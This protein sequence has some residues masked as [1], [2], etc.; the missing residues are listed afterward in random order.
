MLFSRRTL[1]WLAFAGLIIISYWLR[2]YRLDAV[3]LRGD[4]GFTLIHW[5]AP[6][7]SERWQELLR[8]ERHPVGVYMLY[9]AWTGLAGKSV[10]AVRFL[11]VLGGLLGGAATITLARRLL[12]NRQLL[13]AAAFLWMLN[14]FLLWH[15][16]D[17][18]PYS[19]LVATTTLS[20]YW[21]I[22]TLEQS[23]AAQRL[24]LWLP[25]ILIQSIAIYL[26][27][28]EPFW[29]I[30]QGLYVL[31]FYRT[32]LKQAFKAWLAIALLCLPV[33]LQT[34]WLVGGD[35][36]QGDAGDANWQTFF[37]TFVPT[38]F[39]GDNTIGLFWGILFVMVLSVGMLMLIRYQRANLLLW[40]SLVIPSMLLFIVAH[41]STLSRPRYVIAFIPILLIGI[42][43]VLYSVIRR[44]R[45]SIAMP[46][47]FACVALMGIVSIKEINDYFYHDPAKSP[48]W[49]GL[50]S[51]LSARTTPADIVFSG[52][53]DPTIEYYYHKPLLYMPLEGQDLSPLYADLLNRYQAIYLLTAPNTADAEAYFKANSQMILGDTYRGVLQFRAWQVK[54]S[55][56]ENTLDIDF[57]KIARLRG[58]TLVP[59][60]A[61]LD[62]ESSLLFLY[63]EPLSVTATEHSILVHLVSEIEAAGEPPL[64]VAASLD[65]GI[66]GSIIST[67]SWPIGELIRDPISIP[68]DLA[69]G[70]YWIRVGLYETSN[71]ENYIPLADIDLETQF[72]GRY[73]VGEV[74]IR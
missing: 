5:T 53:P 56:I 35:N 48:D 59:S 49:R 40:L 14:P 69:A 21:L 7:F 54:T 41:F 13:I 57:G 4:E 16:Q 51:Y 50:T 29:L 45:P 55:E 70:H 68:I 24:R 38:L 22:R 46:I 18:R 44:L 65:H 43:S 17:A 60:R 31:I 33:A 64:P 12:P 63:W 23:A 9:W 72:S 8:T 74:I 37:T 15:A 28:F 62:G 58:Y 1:A 30:P 6:P 10:F 36:Y 25:Y 20:L 34:Y 61:A 26:Y 71:P 47:T 42:L 3:D 73:V 2:I 27:Y 11:S 66:A 19:F 52:Q 67:T 32:H 39:F